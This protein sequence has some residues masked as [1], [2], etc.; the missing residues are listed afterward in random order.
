MLYQTI[1]Y[2]RVVI[3]KQL[4][5]LPF[6]FHSILSEILKAKYYSA[7]RAQWQWQ[8]YYFLPGNCCSFCLWG[9]GFYK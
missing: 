2:I 4:L 9:V 3:A 7:I 5:C 6:Y 8:N 1:H